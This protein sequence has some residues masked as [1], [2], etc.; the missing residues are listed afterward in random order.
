MLKI[1]PIAST[2]NQ[3]ILALR[4][5]YKSRERKKS[6]LFLVEG[7][8][9]VSR[10]LQSSFEPV[11]IYFCPKIIP[12][13]VWDKI[14]SSLPGGVEIYALEKAV[15]EK[16]AYRENTEGI[17]A[18]FRKKEY[19]FEDIYRQEKKQIFVV[20]EGVEKPGNLG[21]ILR[22][23]DA[24]GVDAIFLTEGKVDAYHPNVV[25]ASLGGV[26]TVPVL[27]SSNTDLYARFRHYNIQTYAAALP[28]YRNMYELPMQETTALIFGTES[29]GLQDFW[30]QKADETYTIP[31]QGIVDSLN[32]SVSVSVSLYEALRQRINVK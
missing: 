25:R 7:I 9:E 27:S 13:T 18:A 15:Y 12:S 20:L 31:M 5:L 26:F 16:I 23:A 22:T 10:G 24:V 11:A 6:N 4:K 17:L 3:K 19:R 1:N 32:V 8:K 21:A 28:A 2:H 30:I 29:T 14:Y